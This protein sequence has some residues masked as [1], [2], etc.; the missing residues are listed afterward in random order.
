[1]LL[2]NS[3]MWDS[4]LLVNAKIFGDASAMKNCIFNTGRRME[5]YIALAI[6]NFPNYNFIFKLLSFLLIWGISVV[7][8]FL[9]DVLINISSSK[10]LVIV[11]CGLCIPIYSLWFELIMF[12]YTLCLFLFLSAILLYLK[13]QKSNSIIKKIVGLSI[14]AFLLFWSFEIQ[15][16]YVFSYAFLFALFLAEYPTNKK[17]IHA[18]FSFLTQHFILILVPIIS[19]WLWGKLFPITGMAK[20]SGYNQ[21][22]FSVQNL[23]Y[24][25]GFSCYKIFVMLPMLLSK[26]AWYNPFTTFFSVLT[27][28]TAAYFFFHKIITT[29]KMMKP[30]TEQKSFNFWVICVIA[31][32]FFVAA[33]LPYNLVGKDYGALNRNCRNGLLTG[34]GIVLFI[35]F[36]ILHWVKQPRYQTVLFSLLF[37][38]FA[39]GSNLSYMYWQSYFVRFQKTEQLL[40][41]NC[42]T[43]KTNYLIITE[44][45]NN[46]M[47]Q[48]FVNYEYNYMCKEACGSEKFLAMDEHSGW[49]KKI[50]TFLIQTTTYRKIFMFSEFDN[51]VDSPIHITLISPPNELFNAEKNVWHYWMNGCNAADYNLKMNFNSVGMVR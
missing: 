23:M 39:T 36:A 13:S 30:E 3:A 28:G 44:Q 5:Y 6:F 11:I 35:V 26:L 34:F 16:F 32:V 4:L 7:C 41:Q 15:S 22:S 40:A 45:V 38:C 10:K 19:F 9:L 24:H 14:S 42:S 37:I 12:S 46:P 51:K 17:F 48:Y 21:I 25:F 50:D 31:L 43:F 29:E 27:S 18:V 20:V 1:M 8:F 33:L 47:Y 2:S 49:A